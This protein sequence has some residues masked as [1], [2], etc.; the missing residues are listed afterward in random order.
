MITLPALINSLRI[1]DK[2]IDNIKVVISGA[3]SAGYGIF[4][5][6]KEAGCKDIVVTDMRR[7]DRPYNC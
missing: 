3:S 6:L 7:K 4:K 2:K 5:I 1:I